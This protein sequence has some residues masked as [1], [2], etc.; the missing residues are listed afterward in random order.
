MSKSPFLFLFFLALGFLFISGANSQSCEGN[1][2]ASYDPNLPCQCND[3]CGDYGN[4]C[5]DY[6]DL[7]VNG[8]G[9]G[10]DS[11]CV[12]RC[13]DT[14][15]DPSKP[16]QCNNACTEY[17]DCCDDYEEVCVNGG[18]GSDSTCV[19]RCGDVPDT[20]KP[21]QCNTACAEYGDCC[22]DYEE[23]C[24]SGGGGEGGASDGQLK[25]ISE[26]LFEL[27]LTFGV[28]NMFEIDVQGSTSSGSSSDNAP[29]PLF[30]SVDEAVWQTGTIPLFRAL[31]DNYD[32]NVNN[33]DVPTSAEQGEEGAFLDAVMESAIMQEAYNFLSQTNIFTGDTAA[34]RTKLYELWFE[35]YDRASSGSA[36]GSSGFEHV[37]IGELKNGETSGF[38]N[39][40]HYAFEELEQ[41][42]INYKGWI[43][44]TTFGGQ[45]GV[46][47][48]FDWQSEPKKYGSMFVG[49]VPELD[50]AVYTIC[51]MARYEKPCGMTYNS[52]PFTVTTYN[53]QYNGKQHIGTAYPDWE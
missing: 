1:C 36:L 12:D 5:E 7:C 37:F 51:F 38:H 16:C 29:L 18:G 41:G 43:D 26:R 28:G 10:S 13:V 14:G 32:A 8:G 46:S 42:S 27:A 22:S 6:E 19:D 17:G 23:V 21:C 20:S 53:Q 34:F 33:E 50:L 49:T 11:S 2:D 47:I 30:T 9:G 40:L 44:K 3:E 52:V 35:N 45:E 15:L 24:N 4:C 39:W 31:F 48:V 25:E